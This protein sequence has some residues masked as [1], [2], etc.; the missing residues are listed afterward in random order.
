VDD[1]IPVI[2]LY[3][4]DN[5]LEK[6]SSNVEEVKARGGQ[7]YMIADHQ[8]DERTI[9]GTQAII[10]FDGRGAFTSPILFNVPFQL[11]AYHAAMI[12]GNSVDQPRNLA[13]SVTVE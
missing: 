11:L 2:I 3:P 10:E 7:V 4:D 12:L 8:V 5:L 13:K 9:V 6:L 1:E